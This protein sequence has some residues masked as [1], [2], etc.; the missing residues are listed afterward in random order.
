MLWM[1]A[2]V[3]VEILGMVG[4]KTTPPQIHAPAIVKAV[5]S[6]LSSL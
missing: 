3:V 1:M 5:T 4:S 2:G 6:F